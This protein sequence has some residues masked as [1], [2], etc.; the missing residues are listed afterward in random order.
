M[1]RKLHPIVSPSSP[2]RS[3]GWSRRGWYVALF[4]YACSFGLYGY[5][6]LSKA[7]TP[8][9]VP[10]GGTDHAAHW[11]SAILMAFDGFD[12]YRKPVSE[13][14]ARDPLSDPEALIPR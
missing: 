1:A 8:M 4:V 11:G 10:Y 6:P 2:R 13:L 14:C 12:I 5:L 9:R 3:R 7:V